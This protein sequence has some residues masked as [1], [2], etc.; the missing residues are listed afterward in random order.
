MNKKRYPIKATG[1]FMMAVNREIIA[2]DD[3]ELLDAIG[4]LMDLSPTTEVLLQG[5]PF[6]VDEAKEN[7]RF[8]YGFDEFDGYGEFDKNGSK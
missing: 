1:S 5:H 6:E 7:G 2:N 3:Q 4:K 8:D